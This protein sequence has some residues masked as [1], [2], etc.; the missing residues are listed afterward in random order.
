MTRLK[1]KRLTDT[2]ACM[3]QMKNLSVEYDAKTVQRCIEIVSNAPTID[4]EPQWIPVSER[5]P[6]VAGLYIV[7]DSKGDVVRF[8]FENTE[9]SR[10]YWRRCAKAW[11]P[12]PRHYEVEE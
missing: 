2:Y 8:I 5:L 4:A 6:K 10:E 9:T 1:M 3:E 11:M 12:L 7:T